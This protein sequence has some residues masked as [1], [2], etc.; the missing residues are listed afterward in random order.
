MITE[1]LIPVLG[2][3]MVRLIYG[4]NTNLILSQYETHTS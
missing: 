2:V 1:E 4:F 3:S